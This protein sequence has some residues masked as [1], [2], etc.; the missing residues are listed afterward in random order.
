[1]SVEVL[2]IESKAL[3]GNGLG[4]PATR[5]LHVIVPDDHDAVFPLPCLWWLAG[6]TGVGRGMLADDPWQEGLEERLV[7]LR[8]A[9]LIGPMLVALPDAFTKLG[10]SQY[11]SSS[12]QGDY[13]TYLWEEC[14]AAVEA[15]FSVSRHAVAGKSSGGYGA[16][17]AAMRRPD[18][19]HAVASH[20][21]DMGFD[22]CYRGD[23][24][25]LMNALHE[26]GGIEKL[27]AAFER[28]LKKKEGRWMGPISAIA[29]AAAYS[30][31]PKRPLG[32]ALPVDL[33]RGAVDEAVFARWKALD[34]IQLVERA[35]HQAALRKMRLFYFECGT[36]DE[37]H[38]Q[39][40]ARVFDKKLAALGISH[41]YQEFDDG[42]RNTSYRLD[43]TLPK[44]WQA[45][46]G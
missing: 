25:A 17:V 11:I 12:A 43:V 39:W 34:P 41:E 44:L 37:Y 3:A 15:R 10:G 40:G 20:S 7:R 23:F 32:I 42:H 16:L 9:G 28:A 38:I 1:M 26:H 29:M 31:D 4:D 33:E 21:G 13:E 35:E 6:Y 19:F 2:R 5:R 36:K 24:P 8:S 46:Q 14:V 45:L 22:L 27:V 18:L 30:A